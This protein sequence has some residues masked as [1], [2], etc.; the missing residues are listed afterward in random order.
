MY[1]SCFLDDLMFKS[2]FCHSFKESYIVID[3]GRWH[4]TSEIVIK[5]GGE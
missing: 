1:N 3:F 4:N 2:L 5:K